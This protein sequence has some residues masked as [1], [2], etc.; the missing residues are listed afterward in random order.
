MIVLKFN[1]KYDMKGYDLMINI[2]NIKRSVAGVANKTVKKTGEITNIAKLTM[3]IKSSEVK[4]EGIYSSIGRLF[5]TSHCTGDDSA[6]E[7]AS[8]ILKADKLTLDIEKLKKELA[9]LRNV[10]VCEGCG[11][12]I[13]ADSSFCSYCGAKVVKPEPEV[14][15]EDEDCCCDC[16][17]CDCECDEECGECECTEEQCD[18]CCGCDEDKAEEEAEAPEEADDNQ[19]E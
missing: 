17:E 7:I 4:L 5:Y 11:S 12:E 3:N 2:E 18:C 13:K 14:P 10:L 8:Y 16:C 9:V 1:I 19:G 15:A 6:E